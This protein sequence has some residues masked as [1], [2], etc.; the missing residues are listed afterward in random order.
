MSFSSAQWTIPEL[1]VWIVTGSRDAVNALTPRVRKSLEYANMIHQGAYA[2]RDR[3]VEAA[4]KGEITVTC[5]GEP[6]HLRG[7]HPRMTLPPVFWTNAEIE[8][9]GSWQA[10]GGLWCVAKRLDRPSEA[11]EFRD[12]LV[13]SSEAK[14]QWV[15]APISVAD[16]EVLGR[17][18][19][20][21]SR[22]R[23]QTAKA[24]QAE[25]DAWYMEHLQ[26]LQAAGLQSNIHEDETAGRQEPP[27]GLGGRADR[28][29]IRKSRESLAPKE[30]R[31]PAVRR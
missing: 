25:H 18:A 21:A 8:D 28:E 2:A 5:A 27:A 9:R 23:Q 20:P 15:A 31:S 6:H 4:Q 12:L 22:S 3:V 16:Q 14:R 7:A 26:R 1:C 29:K 11:T 10:P 24:S 30:W 17:P 13:D 19:P